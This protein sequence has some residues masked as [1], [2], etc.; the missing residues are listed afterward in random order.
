[1][2]RSVTN[3]IAYLLA[4]LSLY[5]AFLPAD[6]ITL[7]NGQRLTGAI[8][9][10]TSQQI[11]VSLDLGSI[12][13]SRDKIAAIEKTGGQQAPAPSSGPITTNSNVEHDQ[14]TALDLEALKAQRSTALA[15][16]RNLNRL[17]MEARQLETKAERANR[18]W[19][20]PVKI[21]AAQKNIRDY[22]SLIAK[23]NT[24]Q[25]QATQKQQ[26][27][28][29]AQDQDLSDDAVEQPRQALEELSKQLSELSQQ[30]EAAKTNAEGSSAQLGQAQA[31]QTDLS[32]AKQA[33][34][35]NHNQQSLEH[36]TISEYL[37]AL[38]SFDES[39]HNTTPDVRLEEVRRLVEQF[40]TEFK[41]VEIPG[42]N[43]GK[44]FI[45]QVRINDQATGRFVV[46]TGAS[47]MTI[48]NELAQRLGLDRNQGPVKISLADGTNMEAKSLRLDSVC[49]NEVCASGVRAVVMPDPPGP[50]LDGLLGMSFL[51]EF[52][53]KLDAKRN[54]V[55]F[56][57]FQG[58]R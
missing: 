40:Q 11:T 41:E 3:K 53:V 54:R 23:H 29:Q 24:L 14:N 20:D 45:V 35:R 18:Q 52:D 47:S 4:L 57:A 32:S 49:V 46:D 22:N 17:Q 28:R 51:G 31:S 58:D 34:E 16:T 2:A 1:M 30:I 5:A 56:K 19:S 44:G 27:L 42:I 55:I 50:G 15:A 10:E 7:T 37:Q 8:L 39:L 43:D 21:Q 33:L 38:E 6:V 26:E 36:Q 48:T 13:L 25:A 9:K 12:T